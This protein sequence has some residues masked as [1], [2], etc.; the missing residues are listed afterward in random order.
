MT[1]YL[2]L[3]LVADRE[4]Q[5]DLFDYLTEQAPVVAGFTAS[6]AEGHGSTA[7]LHTVAEQVKGR[8]DRVIIRIILDEQA[9]DQIIRQIETT[10]ASV[11]IVY[12]T[13]PVIQFGVT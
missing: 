11:N 4:I 1:A 13:T 12:W 8:A 9:A 5:Q 7:R 2:C 3:T 6:E 10:F